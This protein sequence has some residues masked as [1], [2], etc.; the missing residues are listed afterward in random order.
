MSNQPDRGSAATT[1]S[2]SSWT[3][4]G[5]GYPKEDVPVL[6][7]GDRGELAVAVW[8]GESWHHPDLFLK[9]KNVRYWLSIPQ[10]PSEKT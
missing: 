4:I 9:T 1:C 3:C 5:D 7:A 2:L 8:G 6:V 10:P